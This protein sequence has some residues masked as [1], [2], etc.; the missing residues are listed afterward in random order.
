MNKKSPSREVISSRLSQTLRIKSVQK[1]V[2]IQNIDTIEDLDTFTNLP[3]HFYFKDMKEIF[4]MENSVESFVRPK[5]R[6][7]RYTD[8][9][10]ELLLFDNGSKSPNGNK[11]RNGSTRKPWKRRGKDKNKEDTDSSSDEERR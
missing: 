8:T 6:T 2:V 9:T 7:R 3:D 5:K 4:N 1:K 11:K 10:P